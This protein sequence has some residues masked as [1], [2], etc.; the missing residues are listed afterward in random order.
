[1]FSDR[2]QLGMFG[3]VSI[4]ISEP[5]PLNVTL[6]GT[7]VTCIGNADGTLAGLASGGS[8]SYKYQLELQ[9]YLRFQLTLD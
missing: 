6:T 8:G 3:S 4:T 2:Q 9:L 5:S 1:M 7:N